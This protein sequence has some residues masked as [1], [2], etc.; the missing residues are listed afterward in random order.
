MK[1][2]L[3]A[4]A[5]L[6]LAFPAGCA[7]VQSTLDA[8]GLEAERIETLSWVLFAFCGAVLVLVLVLSAIA[9]FSGGASR[10]RISGEWLVVWLGIAFPAVSLTA[11]LF[12]GMWLMGEAGAAAPGAR[13]D[14]LVT[15]ERWW[16][17]VEY[18]G[19]DGETFASANE[20][21]IPVGQ[22]VR[23]GL[24]TADV[25]HSFWVPR[26]AGKLDMIPGRTNVQTLQATSAGTSRGQCA[27]YCGGAHALMSFWVVAMEPAEHAAWLEREAGP[28]REPR[29]Q[30]E[31]EGQRIFLETGC[32]AC[33]AVRGTPANGTLGPDLT[34]VGSRY[35]LGAGILPNDAA[36]FERWIRDSQHVKPGN[37]MPAYGIFTP[38]ELSAV[39]AY[40]DS[41]E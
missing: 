19:P 7:G 38:G 11:L 21:R 14:M 5:V 28:A 40:L 6:A 29:T 12:Y 18:R 35:S 22:P 17:R 16:W 27:E 1:A 36:A 32:G 41:L 23:V 4:I 8:T 20:L 10:S 33:H 30:E 39:A 15:G 3:R 9:L 34:H 26:L 31:R 2:A 37:L 13:N 24:E 25:L